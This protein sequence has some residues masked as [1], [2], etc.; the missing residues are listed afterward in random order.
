MAQISQVKIAG[1]LY[2]YIQNPNPF[3]PTQICYDDGG[4]TKK[5]SITNVEEFITT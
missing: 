2:P 5:T 4:T 1:T 3:E